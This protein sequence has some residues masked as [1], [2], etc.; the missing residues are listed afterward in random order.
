MST[1][2]CLATRVA[3]ARLV[4]GTEGFLCGLTAAWVYGAE[5]QDDRAQLV[6]I[7]RPTGSWRKARSGCLVRQITVAPSDLI[8]VEGALIT[9]PLRTAF[10]CARWLTRTEAVVVADAMA[11]EHFVDG[12][13]LAAYVEAHRGLRGVRNAA[14][15]AT[16][17]DALS[18]SPMES[19]MRVLLVSSGFEGHVLQHEIRDGHGRFV[20]RVDLAY[21]ERRIAVEYDG[22]FHWRQRR[23]DDRRRDKLRALGWQVFVMS[24]SD[25][26]R[27]EGFVAELR[28]A[29][30]AP[31]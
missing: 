27:P 6:W 2:D 4:L 23:D 20:A 17:V 19:R 16:M 26:Y 13:H 21:P 11:R 28:R 22:S 10:D 31:T 7:G 18:E 29:F 24:A 15:V 12:C 5:A 14:H 25:Y 8:T 1:E 9:T 3:A 30:A